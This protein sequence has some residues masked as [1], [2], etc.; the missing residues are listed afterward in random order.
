MNPAAIDDLRRQIQ[1]EVVTP[2]D[3]QYAKSCMLF[4]A[5]LHSAPAVIVYCANTTDVQ[6]VIRWTQAQSLQLSLR[7]GGC[8]VT[9]FS[10]N[11]GG[12]VL[13]VSRLK[14]IEIDPKARTAVVGPGVK[15]GDA[16]GALDPYDLV[17]PGGECSMVGMA[18][19]TLGGGVSLVGRSLGF[20]VDSLVEA[21]MVTATGELV[22]ANDHSHEDLFWALR[23]GGG[24]F[25][26]VTELTVQL[27]PIA[28]QVLAGMLI[29]TIDRA[30]EAMLSCL[31]YFREEAP[32]E[33]DA[34]FILAA[35]PETEDLALMLVTT[36]NGDPSTGKAV[37]DQLEK[38]TAP[39]KVQ[40]Q[41]MPYYEFINGVFHAPRQR[42]YELWKSG[43]VKDPLPL[44]AAE[45][46]VGRFKERP[47]P[48]SFVSFELCGGAMNEVGRSDT[49]FV[50]RDQEFLMAI[51][52]NSSQE[53]AGNRAW[54][55]RLYSE[56]TPFLS[57]EHYQNY[58]DVD[59]DDWQHGYYGE[60]YDRLLEIKSQYDPDDVFRFAQSI[61][62]SPPRDV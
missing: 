6:T 13:D 47:S 8:C 14:Q 31:E 49:A 17:F 57:G 24:S 11:T 51:L 54:A 19:L 61:G 10:T 20:T 53:K 34:I 9:G 12:V 44:E 48:D 33:L 7:A 43:F 50:H 23:G 18:G 25:G 5:A 55:R 58:P 16:Y 52:A 30:A 46:L 27:S 56:I 39:T 40:L 3:P 35:E 38:K 41:P 22:V 1:G 62:A 4:N 2:A 32:R 21:Q 42:V 28:P 15:L 37:L 60:N 45:L 26:T 59:L 36:F 29:W